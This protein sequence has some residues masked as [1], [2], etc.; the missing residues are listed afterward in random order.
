MF[1]VIILALAIPLLYHIQ[2][3]ILQYKP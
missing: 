3:S 2:P 1:N